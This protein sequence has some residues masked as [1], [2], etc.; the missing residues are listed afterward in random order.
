[1]FAC[2]DSERGS[3]YSTLFEIELNQHPDMRSVRAFMYH[4]QYVFVNLRCKLQ[5][6]NSIF[7]VITKYIVNTKLLTIYFH[8]LC[9]LLNK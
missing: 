4:A 1:M 6:R 3:E 8:V 2:P 5:I 7:S 9:L